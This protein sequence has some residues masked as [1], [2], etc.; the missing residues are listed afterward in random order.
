MQ[1]SNWNYEIEIDK[2]EF[3]IIDGI[4]I[5]SVNLSKSRGLQ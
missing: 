5:A 2:N 4:F 3:E 1:T